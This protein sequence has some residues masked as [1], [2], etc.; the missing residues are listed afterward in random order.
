VVRDVCDN[1]NVVLAL[2]AGDGRAVE[3]RGVT[4]H[5]GTTLSFI[6]VSFFCKKNIFQVQVQPQHR[7]QRCQAFQ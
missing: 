3:D 7:L 1:I 6:Q 4:S 5:L 2:V